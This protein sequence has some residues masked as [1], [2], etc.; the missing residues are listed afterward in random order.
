M[1]EELEPLKVELGKATKAL[2]ESRKKLEDT[3]AKMGE[4]TARSTEQEA[5]L[6]KLAEDHAKLSKEHDEIITKLQ[7]PEGN[8][9]GAHPDDK[10]GQAEAQRAYAKFLRNQ[11]HGENT[12]GMSEAEKVHILTVAEG[13][14]QNRSLYVS[15]EE[16][17]GVLVNPV[18][19]QRMVD[20]LVQISRL[21]EH[22]T[23]MSIGSGEE[24]KFT[25]ETGVLT[26][27]WAAERSTRTETTGMEWKGVTIPT[28]EQ[29]ALV[30]PTMRLLDDVLFNLEAWIEGRVTKQF[31]RAEG[32]A[33]LTGNGV[34]KPRGLL[35]H[36]EVEIV[37]ADATADSGE[38]LPDDV[39]D[40]FAELETEYAD[41][42]IALFSRLT[43]AFMR[44]FKDKNDRRLD[45]VQPDVLS[46]IRSFL[47]DGYPS[48][49]MPNMANVG[50]ASAKVMAFGDIAEAYTIVD[51]AL[52]TVIRDPFTR[53]TVGEVELMYMRRVGGD[54]VNP[55][56]VKIL[57][58][59]A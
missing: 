34:G 43:L 7:S 39:T 32:I 3:E 27:G 28:H 45:L 1:P 5:K 17:G 58:A 37:A 23:V 40:L 24:L 35:V 18:I 38:F 59:N 2:L 48:R 54:V 49:E 36:P 21:R 29:Y 26:T 57:R 11:S 20:K 50:V 41:N 8:L 9:P 46:K 30:R 19:S 52:M 31:G 12:R 10:K 4:V 47:I 22:A 55:D 25:R 44:K 16:M 51:R 42:A 56:A 53:K 13:T 14:K 33:F 15:N 6:T